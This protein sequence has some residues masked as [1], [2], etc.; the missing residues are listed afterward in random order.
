MRKICSIQVIRNESGH[1]LDR[2]Q[3]MLNNKNLG[4]Q[5]RHNI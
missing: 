2:M 5:S 4:S 1:N 3:E